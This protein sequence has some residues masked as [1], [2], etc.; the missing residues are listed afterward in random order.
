MLVK[1]S[2]QGLV[3][4]T[5]I[6]A[7]L[8]ISISLY[9]L[10]KHHDIQWKYTLHRLFVILCG[11]GI[12]WILAQLCFHLGLRGGRGMAFIQ[13]AFAGGISCIGYFAF[14]YVFHLPQTLLHLDFAVL[15]KKRKRG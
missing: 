3:F 15:F 2:Y 7:M 5:V 4:S 11:C 6:S 9:E 10:T 13:M 14:T 12:L 8:N 1:F